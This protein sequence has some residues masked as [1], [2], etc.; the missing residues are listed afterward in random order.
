MATAT[1]TCNTQACGTK[2][3]KAAYMR[4][5]YRR[6]PEKLRAKNLQRAKLRGCDISVEVYNQMFADQGGKCAICGQPETAMYRGT[7]RN[8]CV[9][10]NHETGEVRGLLCNFCNQGLGYFKDNPELLK[11]ASAYLDRI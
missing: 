11:S 10:H 6:N 9:D 3:C 5:Y 1:C 8:L 2:A 4:D 7:V